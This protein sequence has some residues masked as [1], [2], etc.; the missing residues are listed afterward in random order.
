MRYYGEDISSN[1]GR[2]LSTLQNSTDLNTTYGIGSDTFVKCA[3]VG[4]DATISNLYI[5]IKN[6]NENMLSRIRNLMSVLS[7][8]YSS[9][10]RTLEEVLVKV[11]DVNQKISAVN[12]SLNKVNEALGTIHA[13]KAYLNQTEIDSLVSTCKKT[14]D[15]FL[16]GFRDKVMKTGTDKESLKEYE[17]V[18]ELLGVSSESDETKTALL[19]IVVRISGLG[20]PPETEDKMANRVFDESI[21]DAVRSGDK[22]AID[23]ALKT[24]LASDIKQALIANMKNIYDVDD[25]FDHF[26]NNCSMDDLFQM[27]PAFFDTVTPFEGMDREAQ[28]DFMV[29]FAL[30]GE[31]YSGPGGDSLENFIGD[32]FGLSGGYWCAMYSIFCMEYCGFLNPGN[33]IAPG[34]DKN[35]VLANGWTYVAKMKDGF[36]QDKVHMYYTSVDDETYDINYK[37]KVGDFMLCHF[38]QEGGRIGHIAQVVG[39]DGDKIY[40]IEGNRHNGINYAVYDMSKEREKERWWDVIGFLEMGGTKEDM[41]YLPEDIAQRAEAD[42][43]N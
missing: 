37:P 21:V 16:I 28:V 20:L 31:G 43:Y 34:C 7:E 12:D 26:V 22:A 40:T 23:E 10:D 36:P 30:A 41:S 35:N 39:I 24:A 42:Q 32:Y 14:R 6:H 33:S 19:N 17:K 8:M 27:V 9:T 3:R 29:R 13:K 11:A 1:I 25:Y 38:L 18:F 2:S 15:M 4:M 5:N